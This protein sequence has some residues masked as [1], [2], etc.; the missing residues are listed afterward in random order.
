MQA[1][2]QAAES[3]A[4]TTEAAAAAAKIS[5]DATALLAAAR[6]AAFAEAS[7]GRLGQGLSLLFEAIDQEPSSH[8]LLSD[9]AALLLAAGDLVQAASYAQR[10]LALA[11]R[12]GPS[13]YTL[14][15]AS[16]GMGE[17]VLATELLQ[18]LLEGEPLLS[19]ISEAP[20][21]LPL[22]QTELTRLQTL[23]A[24]ESLLA[25]TP[26]RPLTAAAA[27]GQASA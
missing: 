7:R 3:A 9:V 19:L 24:Q 16:S 27:R 17:R 8:E 4:A 22:V 18:Q 23:A 26:L 2:Q 15:F 1:T 14:A 6:N 10:A 5:Q 25:Q 20:D 12:H 21:L 11:P 13:L